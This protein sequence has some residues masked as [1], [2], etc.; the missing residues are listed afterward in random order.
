MTLNEITTLCKH[1]ADARDRLAETSEEIKE[2]RRRAIRSRLRSLKTRVAEVSTAKD[3]LRAALETAPELFSK[4]RTL[5]I[6]GIKIGFR[7]QPGRVECT[8]VYTINRIR[9]LLPDQAPDLIRIKES[10]NRPALK[11]LDSKM[12]A[13]VGVT[14]AEVDDEVVIQA[15]SSDLDKLVDALLADGEEGCNEQH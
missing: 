12:L 11:N 3:A 10:L 1:Y 2:L 13:K 7:K 14:V 15:A 8:E 5:A 9:K 4:P 6:E